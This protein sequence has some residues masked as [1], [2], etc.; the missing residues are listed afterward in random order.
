MLRLIINTD[1]FR[2][3]CGNAAN[4]Y[5]G[6][7]YEFSPYTGPPPA[8]PSDQIQD[9]SDLITLN[10]LEIVSQPTPGQ[11][12]LYHSS[13]PPSVGIAATT[14]VPAGTY[15]LTLR[16]TDRKGSGLSTDF[17]FDLVV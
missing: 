5:N 13:A 4:Y 6:V 12:E 3:G 7:A 2:N 10:V 17:D 14:A 1:F 15:S 9:A 16:V 11:F 8:G